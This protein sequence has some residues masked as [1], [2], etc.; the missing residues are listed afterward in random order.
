MRHGG[1]GEV[2][3]DAVDIDAAAFARS[4]RRLRS[5]RSPTPAAD[6]IE[7]SMQTQVEEGVAERR[8]VPVEDGGDVSGSPAS[9]WQLSSLRSLWTIDHAWRVSGPTPPGSSATSSIAG[10]GD[11]GSGASPAVGPAGHL[12]IG[13]SRRAGRG[14]RG[15][16]PSTSTVWRSAAASTRARSSRRATSGVTHMR[17][18]AL[19]S[20]TT[21]RSAVF[22]HQE[23]RADDRTASSLNASSSRGTGV[24]VG[25]R[26]RAPCFAGHVVGARGEGAVWAGGGPRVERRRC[27]PGRSG[28][29]DLR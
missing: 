7:M 12:A 29:P 3:V 13:R 16:R 9:N 1:E 8:H 27:R 28:W 15:R 23:R 20:R 5:W 4:A 18:L 11:L 25:Q 2:P 24:G 17:R 6:P 21:C 22:D 14:R 10:I 19:V 26:R